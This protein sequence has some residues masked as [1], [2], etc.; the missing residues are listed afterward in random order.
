MPCILKQKTSQSPGII[1][2]TQNEVLYGFMTKSSKVKKYLEENSKNRK[3]IYGVHIQGDCSYMKEWPLETWQSFIM[4]LDVKASFLSNVP[5]EKLM[6]MN[7]INFMPDIEP[8]KDTIKKWD[9]CV[10]SRS[11]KIKR[12]AETVYTIKKLMAI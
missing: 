5:G 6:D 10:A 7:C 11:S 1:T 4:W 9:I 8:Q 2:F 12:I 3:W